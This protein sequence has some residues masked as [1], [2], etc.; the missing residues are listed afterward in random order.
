MTKTK[1]HLVTSEEGDWQA[2]YVDGVCQIQGHRLS[3]IQVLKSLGIQVEYITMPI[4]YAVCPELLEDL[5]EVNS[6]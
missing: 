4:G 1:Y 3:G 6:G 2:L 5:V